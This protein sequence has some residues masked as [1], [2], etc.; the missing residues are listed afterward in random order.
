MNMKKMVIFDLDGTLLDAVPDITDSANVTMEKF[1]F[2][3]RTEQEMKTFVGNGARKIVERSV[4]MELPKEKIDEMLA[5]YNDYYTKHSSIRTH[6]FDGV[7]EVL[8]TLKERGYMIAIVTNKPQ[9]TTNVVYDIYLKDFGFEKAIGPA[10]GGSCKPEKETTLNLL[11]E[12]DV[13]PENAYFVGDGEA[14]VMVAIN[15]GVKGIA[16]LWGYRNKEQLQAVGATVFCEK[17]LG[18]LDIIL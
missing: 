18:L 8:K 4:G 17:P 10:V 1:G 6:L 2:K 7:P 16:A 11:K 9:K 14:D 3:K 5:F 13:L 12:Y 15:A